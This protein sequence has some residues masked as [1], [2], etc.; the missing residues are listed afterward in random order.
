MTSQDILYYSLAVGFLILVGFIS[1]AAFSLSKT[2]KE[3]SSILKKVDDITKDVHELKNHIKNGILYL[4]N[5]LVRKGGE[6]NGK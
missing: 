5:V 3:L 4:K 2:L 1:Y 6:K